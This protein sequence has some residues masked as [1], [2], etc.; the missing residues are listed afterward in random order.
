ME[1]ISLPGG[2]PRVAII[3][4]PGELDADRRVWG[5]HDRSLPPQGR[6]ALDWLTLCRFQRRNIDL[7]HGSPP[8]DLLQQAECVIVAR[9]PASIGPDDVAAL[10]AALTSRPIVVI[11]RAA[12]SGHPLQRLSGAVAEEVR[13]IEGAPRWVGP[14][15]AREWSSRLRL[16]GDALRIGDGC[17][18]WA[19][20]GEAPLVVV[21][22]VGP[23]TIVT[24]AADPSEIR[25][26]ES[27]GTGLLAWLLRHALP[28]AGTL[29]LE[30]SL[31][32]R[33]DDP[34]S[35]ANVHLRGWAHRELG[36]AEWREVTTALKARDARMSA[37]YVPGWIDDGD[38][39]RGE[40]R[41]GGEVVERVPGG[42]HPAPLVTY[43]SRDGELHDYV[44]EAKGLIAL[45][46]GGA[47]GVEQHGFTHVRPPYSEWAAAPDRYGNVAWYRE[48]E[49]FEEAGEL[50]CDLLP[51]SGNNSQDADPISLGANVLQQHFEAR[52]CTLTFPGQAGSDRATELALDAGFDLVA[53]ETLA[54]RHHDRFCWSA[55]VTSPGLEFP[56]PHLL[57]TG[58]P[59]VATLHDRDIVLNGVEWLGRWLDEWVAAGARR[60]IDFGELARLLAG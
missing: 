47:G 19:F 10:E 21:R 51:D 36:E 35:A 14:G 16:S 27:S 33:M 46:E 43:R 57:E 42:V 34:G 17:V 52:P 7:V 39:E 30:G 58:L 5:S 15:P 9:H 45:K 26:S 28:D 12:P 29:D 2:R 38:G 50:S 32:L 44:A 31:V 37:C 41:V 40:L 59:V 23:G 49:R 25:D 4:E 48:F 20:A 3:A 6:E 18:P 8:S 60:V 1:T 13:S 24:L 55:H 22:E 54:I 53:T 56:D 11:A